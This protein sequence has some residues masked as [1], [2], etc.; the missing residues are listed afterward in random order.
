MPLPIAGL[1]IT[2]ASKFAPD[3]LGKIAGDKAGKVAE[4]V[5]DLAR[6]VTGEE[7]P[8]KVEAA[9]AEHPELAHEFQMKAMELDAEIEKAYLVDRQDARARDVQLALA[10]QHNRRGD[11]L[12][13]SAVSALLILVGVAVFHPPA[14]EWGQSVLAGAI[15]ALLMRVADVF[16]FEFGSSRGSKEKSVQLAVKD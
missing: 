12:A 4:Q 5:V 7:E 8:D 14:G 2:L 13:Y 10:G 6:T 1:A 11:V 16:A 15:G 3:L 9:L